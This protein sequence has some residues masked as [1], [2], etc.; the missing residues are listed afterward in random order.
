M[1]AGFMAASLLCLNSCGD[2]SQK[3]AA[4][5]KENIKEAGQDL[6]EAAKA[7]NEEAK[8]KATADWQQF[9]NESDSAIAGME[10]QIEKLKVK[11]VK[12]DKK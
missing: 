4:D 11:I 8:T 9:K 3:H 7:A 5:A 12:A 10:E 2:A 6:K 1:V